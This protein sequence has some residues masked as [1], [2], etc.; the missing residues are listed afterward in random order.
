M[1]GFRMVPAGSNQ[2]YLLL[3]ARGQQIAG[4]LY[5]PGAEAGL[6]FTSL[7]RM[8]LQLEELMDTRGDT[9]EPWVPPEGFPREAMELEILFRQN[10]SWQGRLKW[11][12]AG[13]EAVFHSVLELIFLLETDLNK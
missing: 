12:A 7:S 5:G 9:W 11:P 6:P 2:Y 4:T 8:V 1:Q 3:E 13:K 10:Y